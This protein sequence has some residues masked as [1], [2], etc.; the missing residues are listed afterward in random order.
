M[1]RLVSGSIAATA[2]SAGLC[3]IYWQVARADTLHFSFVFASVTF[4]IVCMHWLLEELDLVRYEPSRNLT[5][6]I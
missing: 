1:R 6:E 2:F 5:H 4:A 3:A